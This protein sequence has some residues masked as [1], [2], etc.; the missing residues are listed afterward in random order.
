MQGVP[1]HRRLKTYSALSGYVFQYVY[2]GYRRHAEPPANDYIFQVGTQRSDS[3][4][5]PIRVSDSVAQ[6]LHDA[7]GR[8]ISPREKYALAKM[9]LFRVLD[10]W[11]AAPKDSCAP[12][13]VFELSTEE[14]IEIWE[15]L[16][17]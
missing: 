7:S 2:A 9:K 17:L 3:M 4:P 12:G 6:L 16:G 13:Q 11:E 14:A 8:E 5:L 15:T 1:S 10:E